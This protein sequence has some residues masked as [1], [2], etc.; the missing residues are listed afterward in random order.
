MP[1]KFWRK[2]QPYINYE[3]STYK[4]L[5][6]PFP[7]YEYLFHKEDDFLYLVI[8]SGF[9][10]GWLFE[11]FKTGKDHISENIKTE[12]AKKY[13]Q[14]Y[15]NIFTPV[16]NKTN[17]WDFIQWQRKTLFTPRANEMDSFNNYFDPRFSEWT[18]LEFI[19]QILE[20]SKISG[21]DFFQNKSNPTKFHPANFLV[22]NVIIQE[23]TNIISWNTWR[24]TI[25][26][27]MEI[28]A[29]DSQISDE[30]YTTKGLLELE[31]EVGEKAKVYALG[32][33]LL[34]L[35]IHDTN[36]PWIWNSTDKS[37][38]WENL[39]Y[40]K[41]QN[42]PISSCTMLILQSCF[43]SK[44]R[45]SFYNAELFNSFAT[46]YNNGH[47]DTSTD[48]PLINNT[49]TLERYIIQAQKIIERYQL[50]MEDNNPRQ[51][52]PISLVQLSGENN[53]FEN[54]NNIASS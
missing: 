42:T 22:S 47:G 11:V 2:L 8:N 49:D 24:E 45:E 18:A 10:E 53:P 1:L 3:T 35:I 21:E 43:S 44:N 29:L 39:L 13:P 33:I 46:E 25:Q 41:I 32:I 52:I 30:R 12:L 40:K 26:N 16:D 34:Q 27:V 36:F 28:S 20:K 31:Q 15:N 6:Q 23:S 51:L 38:I 48:P 54:A 37:L 4:P 14:L 5:I 7:N 9:D 50:S 19:R 17:L